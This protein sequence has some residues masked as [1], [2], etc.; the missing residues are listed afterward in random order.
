VSVWIGEIGLEFYSIAAES[1]SRK[2]SP[3]W[4]TRTA[5]VVRCSVGKTILTTWAHRAAMMNEMQARLVRGGLSDRRAGPTRKGLRECYT[6]LGR[7]GERE[8]GPK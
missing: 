6:F 7:A 3:R 2:P 4:S 5:A 8:F 1:E